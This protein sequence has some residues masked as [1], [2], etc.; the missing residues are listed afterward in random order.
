MNSSVD[1]QGLAIDRGGTSG[2]AVKRKTHVW[3]RY[4]LPLVLISGFLSLVGWAAWDTVFPPRPVTV[5]PVIATTAEVQQEGTPLFNA[6]GWIEP[7]PTPIRVAALAPGVVEKLLVV[8]D[9]PV[10]QGEPVAELV[11]DDAKLAYDRALADLKLRKAE[12]AEAKSALKAAI[13]RLEQPVH[14]EAVLCESQASL[15]RIQTEL[16]NLPF[17][18]KRAIADEAAARKDYESKQAAKGVVSGVDIDIAKSKF[19]SAEALVQELRDRE[20][21]LKKEQEG[22]NGRCVAMQKELEL[23]ADEIEAK[24]GA[25]ARLQAAEARVEQAD[26]AR[27]E[28]KLRLDR[29]TIPAPVDGRVYR[30]IA[31]PGARIGSGMTQMQGH[32]GSTIVTMYQPDKLQVRV[33]VRFED[34]PKVSLDQTVE[35]DNAALEEPIRGTVLFISSEADIQKNTL[36]V[37]VGIPD[38]PRVFKPEMLVDATFL[39]PKAPD[40]PEEPSQK[41]KLYVPRQLVQKDGS[42]QF[43]WLADQSDGVAEKAP[44]ETGKVGN[45]GLVEVT[46][47]L[48]VSSRLI[49]EGRKEL[50]PGDRIRVQGEETSLGAERSVA[51]V[52]GSSDAASPPAQEGTD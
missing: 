37:K 44:I 18:L 14:L 46:Q 31:H 48:T 3:S 13:T 1:L 21:S 35:I 50:K 36:Q 39:A 2:P 22:L 16:K 20:D 52:P 7:R 4:V 9:Q 45:N 33:D 8:E 41:L 27:A 23:L 24:E 11:K 43:V 49:V 40:R 38:P 15:A 17:Q 5:I 6:A 34:I 51:G 42:D 10:K 30:L 25:E 19:D 12:L 47:G 29:M 32:D 26:V 28:A